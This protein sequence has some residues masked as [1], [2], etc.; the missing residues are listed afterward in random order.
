MGRASRQIP[1]RWVGQKVEVSIKGDIGTTTGEVIGVDKRG[2][3]L[4]EEIQPEPY[5]DGMLEDAEAR[6]YAHESIADARLS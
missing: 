4:V 6:F 5:G 2:V 1:Q 3:Q